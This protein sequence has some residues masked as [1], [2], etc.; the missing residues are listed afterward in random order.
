[1]DMGKSHNLAGSLV[2]LLTVPAVLAS[3]VS[4]LRPPGKDLQLSLRSAMDQVEV[5]YRLYVPS[6][7]NGVTPL[8]LVVALHGTTGNQNTFFEDPCNPDGTIAWA[9]ERHGMLVV[10]PYGRGSK[11][12]RGIAENTSLRCWPRFARH[13]EWTPIESI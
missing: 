12:Y 8:P 6:K 1:M 13:I 7:Y 2:F 10:G 9:A 11:E 5:Q 4:D 3:P